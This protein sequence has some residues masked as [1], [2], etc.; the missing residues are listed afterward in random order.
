MER[1]NLKINPGFIA[2]LGVLNDREV[3][4][5]WG[6]C[7]ST[8]YDYRTSLGIKPSRKWSNPE[9]HLRI[10][11][12]A[13]DLRIEVEKE[14]SMNRVAKKY[15]VSRQAVHQKLERNKCQKETH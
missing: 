10:L 1:K 7:N 9:K 3:A 2:D 12:S 14:G 11:P 4:E 15:G 8:V 5:K 6:V 13:E